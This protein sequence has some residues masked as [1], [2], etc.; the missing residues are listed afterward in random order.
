MSS[1]WVSSVWARS[2]RPALRRDLAGILPGS[3]EQQARFLDRSLKAI[4]IHRRTV[5]SEGHAAALDAERWTKLAAAGR[6]YCA[7]VGALCEEEQDLLE[8]ALSE[9]TS[10]WQAA[11]GRIWPPR[12]GDVR[13]SAHWA[14]LTAEAA[15]RLADEIAGSHGR[16]RP[17]RNVHLLIALIARAYETSFHERPSYAREGIFSRALRALFEAA[18][19]GPLSETPLAQALSRVAT[20]MPPLRRGRKARKKLP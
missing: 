11:L 2:I 12:F 13:R 5:M 17:E 1:G 10:P 8:A 3:P 20:D 14:Q 9:I 18:G 16:G 6:A 4:D 19:I 7:A 15:D